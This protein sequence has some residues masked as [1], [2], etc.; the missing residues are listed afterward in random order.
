MSAEPFIPNWMKQKMERESI[1]PKAAAVE[2]KCVMCDEIATAFLTRIINGKSYEIDLCDD[3]NSVTHADKAFKKLV[4]AAVKPSTKVPSKRQPKAPKEPKA[5]KPAW[6]VV[7]RVY[8]SKAK[9]PKLRRGVICHL[10]YKGKRIHTVN[11]ATAQA[12]LE[13]KAK[14]W[15]ASGYAPEISTVRLLSDM[16]DAERTKLALRDSPELQFGS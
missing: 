16:S 14:E 12:N 2:L 6:T 5:P 10:R 13:A 4:D 15:N 1:K 3:H 7:T 11:G 9:N 8:E